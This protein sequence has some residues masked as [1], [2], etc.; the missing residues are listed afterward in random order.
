MSAHQSR[1][2]PL[3]AEFAGTIAQLKALAARSHDAAFTEG[4]VSPD[5]HLLDLCADALH[6]LKH[7]NNLEK[8]WRE[9]WDAERPLKAE[10]RAKC[11]A[12]NAERH[13]L[14][15]QAKQ[16]MYRAKK[17]SAKTPGGIYAKAML[18]RVS[19]TGATHLAMS[20]A[21]DMVNCKELRAVLWAPEAMAAG[22]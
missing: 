9:R 16:I 4:E 12:L 20:L 6:L 14:E 3:G 8:E 19:V 7:A 15:T 21:E 5:R 22:D 1:R 2:L 17:M 11:D 18:V 13:R 10:T